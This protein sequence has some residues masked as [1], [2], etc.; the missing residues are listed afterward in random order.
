MEPLHGLRDYRRRSN[1]S[2]KTILLMT[3][4][5]RPGAK[6]R[7]SAR[8]AERSRDALIRPWTSA[9]RCRCSAVFG[10][11]PD[12]FT[13]G[14]RLRIAFALERAASDLCQLHL[15]CGTPHHA[16]C[17]A[18]Y[19]LTEAMRLQSEHKAHRCSSGRDLGG[20]LSFA[21]QRNSMRRRRMTPAD[22][23]TNMRVRCDVAQVRPR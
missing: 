12:L 18:S 21:V 5:G 4:P 11:G 20:T 9:P 2:Y 7:R 6:S 3:P 19:R 13:S 14:C 17:L 15:R 10:S 22:T 1:G 23:C 8:A 16:A